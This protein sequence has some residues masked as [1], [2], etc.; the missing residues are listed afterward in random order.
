VKVIV[1]KTEKILK[2]YFW[3]FLTI[4][5]VAMQKFSFFKAPKSE[6]Y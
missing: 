1:R 6:L 2:F 3:K 5:I 4:T